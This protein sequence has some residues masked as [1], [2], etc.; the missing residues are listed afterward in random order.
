MSL[1]W[2][3]FVSLTYLLVIQPKVGRHQRFTI[4]PEQQGDKVDT[5]YY[6]MVFAA[7]MVR[8]KVH[9]LFCVWLVE[10]RVS[11]STSNPPSFFS[12]NLP[13]SRHNAAGSG[14]FLRSNLV[15]ASWDGDDDDEPSSPG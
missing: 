8:D 11:S 14:G 3:F 5:P 4:G 12:T 15:K 6:I 9:L 2:S 1:K 10:R 7:P 13:D